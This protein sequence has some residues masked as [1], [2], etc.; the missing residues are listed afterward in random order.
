MLLYGVCVC[1]C[2]SLPLLHSASEEG[3]A[4][5]CTLQE[6][7]VNVLREECDHIVPAHPTTHTPPIF[8]SLHLMLSLPLF[9]SLFLSISFLLLLILS[10]SGINIHSP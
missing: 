1:V 2:V 4:A 7:Y 6:G 10:Q 8:L 5:A 3:V 9:P